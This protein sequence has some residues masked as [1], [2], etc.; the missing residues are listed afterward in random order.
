MSE[1]ESIDDALAGIDADLLRI[2]DRVL[3][4]AAQ[5][6]AGVDREA[7]RLQILLDCLAT[8]KS[9]NDNA[10]ALLKAA[11]SDTGGHLWAEQMAAELDQR[12]GGRHQ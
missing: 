3:D 8:M 2:R 12:L 4:R 7:T 5:M 1:A 11:I 6:V 9:A 10:I